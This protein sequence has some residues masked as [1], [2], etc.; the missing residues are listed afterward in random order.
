MVLLNEAGPSN[1]ARSSPSPSPSL[2]SLTLPSRSPSNSL[3]STPIL[4]VLPLPTQGPLLAPAVAIPSTIPTSAPLPAT[5]TGPPSPIP[6]QF[7][8]ITELTQED[9]ETFSHVDFT[10]WRTGIF[11]QYGRTDLEDLR[12]V[13]NNFPCAAKALW[14]FFTSVC[15]GSGMPTELEGVEVFE[16]TVPQ[17]M[18]VDLK[19][20]ISV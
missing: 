10:T 13:A 9:P 6:P 18:N 7:A 20:S 14:T 15:E 2:T 17:L 11:H 3:P 1:R 5:P 4:P 16:V 8:N 19:R 12:I